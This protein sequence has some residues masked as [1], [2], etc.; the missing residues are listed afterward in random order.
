ME[1][2]KSKTEVGQARVLGY[3]AQKNRAYKDEVYEYLGG[4]EST[5]F[6]VEQGPPSSKKDQRFW[7]PTGSGD[8]NGSKN[9]V[10]NLPELIMAIAK[11]NED[12]WSGFPQVRTCD[13][14]LMLH[15]T[16]DPCSE[17]TCFYYLRRHRTS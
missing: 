14:L 9:K 12:I 13:T 10:A 5:H 8:F 11:H 16:C 17:S 7:D 6:Q 15:A 3:V 4:Y 1:S 2:Y